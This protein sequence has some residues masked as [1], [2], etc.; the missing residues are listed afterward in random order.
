[1]LPCFT[2]RKFNPQSATLLC[3]LN[4]LSSSTT[5]CSPPPTINFGSKTAFVRCSQS[6][7]ARD[8][9]GMHIAY[10]PDLPAHTVGG[11]SWSVIAWSSCPTSSALL[12]LGVM[13]KNAVQSSVAGRK[14]R[15][16]KVSCSAWLPVGNASMRQPISSSSS[17]STN[18]TGTES[19]GGFTAARGRFTG[20]N[21]MRSPFS[22][23]P[24]STVGMR[25][26]SKGDSFP[27]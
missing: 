1:M 9:R 18:S 2:D 26:K 22:K 27:A 25:S 11:H 12:T 7:D 6:C 24:A 5:L 17:P 4:P 13:W 21:R 10:N 16:P 8:K 19:A 15:H 20:P 23:L 3:A 14:P